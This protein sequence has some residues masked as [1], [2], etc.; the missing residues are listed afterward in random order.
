MARM[1]GD[2]KENAGTAGEGVPDRATWRSISTNIAPTSKWN[3][4]EGGRY[5]LLM[6]MTCHTRLIESVYYST[7]R[8]VYRSCR[9]C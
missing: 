6:K 4:E 2:T 8:V 1:K 3:E 7:C 5:V 9:E